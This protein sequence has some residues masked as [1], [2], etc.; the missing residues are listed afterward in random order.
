VGAAGGELVYR[1][2][3]A[4]AYVAGQRTAELPAARAAR[5]ERDDD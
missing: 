2:G 1:H 3:A 5:P 4:S